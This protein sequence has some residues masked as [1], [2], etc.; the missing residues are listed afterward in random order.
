MVVISVVRAI[1]HSENKF[2]TRSIRFTYCAKA[3]SQAT[4]SAKKLGAQSTSFTTFG[5]RNGAFLTDTNS[6]ALGLNSDPRPV[7][8]DDSDFLGGKSRSSE[9]QIHA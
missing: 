1:L 6:T 8:D 3:N 4:V 5:E 2:S 9:M 7:H